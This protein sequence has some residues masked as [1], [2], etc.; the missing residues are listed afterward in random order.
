MHIHRDLGV[1]QKAALHTMQRIR[2]AFAAGD[3]Q[4]LPGPRKFDKTSM[5]GLAATPSE[6]Q[7]D[8]PLTD[9]TLKPKPAPG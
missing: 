4:K 3:V 9:S 8:A 2:E 7:V 1:T 5:G 6:R